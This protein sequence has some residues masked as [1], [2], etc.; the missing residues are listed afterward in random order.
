M[1]RQV[2]HRVEDGDDRQE[3]EATTY[4]MRNPFKQMR[5][6]FFTALDVFNYMH[7]HHIAKAFAKRGDRVLDVCCGRGIMLPL[8]RYHAPEIAC[9]V[10]VD[11][12]PKNAEWLT[13]R[14]TDGK[15]YAELK[16]EAG[17]PYTRDTYYP[18]P[19]LF[20]ESN[21]A[22]M[23]EPVIQA[24]TSQSSDTSDTSDTLG[25][26]ADTGVCPSSQTSDTSDQLGQDP[27]LDVYQKSPSNQSSDTSDG[28]VVGVNESN[29]SSDRLGQLGQLGQGADTGVRQSNPRSQTSD[30]L[31]HLGQRAS[32]G[33]LQSIQ[34][35]PSSDKLG[36]LGQFDLIIYTQS[37][38]HM[39][40][41]AG[42]ASLEQ[43]AELAAPT[44]RLILSG[45][46]TPADQDGYDARY[47][48]H[49]YEWKREELLDALFDTGWRVER[50]WGLTMGSRKLGEMMREAGLVDQWEALSVSVPSEWLAPVLAPLFPEEA[51]E[52][53]ILAVRDGDPPVE[54]LEL[55]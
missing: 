32:T 31:G 55:V 10:G 34:S 47:R 51:D 17:V 26:G 23:A 38:E 53:A 24:L 49:V 4:Q 54:Q 9:Y 35:N 29:Q 3:I 6:G 11:I 15:Y 40:P 13:K 45:P 21:V 48:A 42:F 33:A 8:L 7:H 46:N 41:E 37:I 2:V 18:F 27:D 39:H 22:T 44:C 28:T 16:A 52:I 36:Q 43:C 25:L 12:E 1:T 5:D 50:E 19:T 30:Q 14:V 20:V